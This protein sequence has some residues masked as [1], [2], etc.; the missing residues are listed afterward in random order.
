V[1]EAEWLAATDP[2][3]MLDFLRDKASERKLRLFAVGCCYHLGGLLEGPLRAGVE[4]AEEYAD[5]PATL[6]DQAK[7]A[8]GAVA[9]AGYLADRRAQQAP[10]SVVWREWAVRWASVA[11]SSAVEPR[12][13]VRSRW[14]ITA[15]KYAAGAAGQL[16]RSEVR[17]DRNANDEAI[18][19]ERG[20]RDEEFSY[21]CDLLRCVFG[22]V[23]FGPVTIDPA[24]LTPVVKQLARP[25][26]ERR[27][28]GRLPVLADALEEAGCSDA[29]LLGH[30][31]GPGP[32]VRGCWALDLVLGR[33]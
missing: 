20:A 22:P 15:S 3:P 32:H 24:W 7:E 10:W 25:I 28:F 9:R 26:Y 2:E 19:I 5:A 27:A 30:L 29:D 6:A 17:T 12:A 11:V 18:G 33:G 23:A 4:V 1:T 8:A 21:Q 14:F 31:R 13:S 16:A